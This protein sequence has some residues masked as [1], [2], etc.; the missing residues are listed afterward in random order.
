MHSCAEVPTEK[1]KQDQDCLKLLSDTYTFIKR[2][3]DKETV[4]ASLVFRLSKDSQ[5]V[6][7]KVMPLGSKTNKT[8][9][10]DVRIACILNNLEQTPV[11]VKTSGWIKCNQIPPLWIRNM[12]IKKDAP[13]AFESARMFLFQVMSFSSHSWTDGEIKLDLEEYRV[14]LFLLLHGLWVAE[15]KIHFRHNDI[16]KG[17]I[18]FQACK[19]N[20]SITISIGE[21]RYKVTCQRFVPKLIDFGHATTSKEEEE[22]EEEEYSSEGAGLFER[23]PEDLLHDDVKQLFYVFEERMQQEGLEPFKRSKFWTQIEDILLRD[24]IFENIR[25]FSSIESGYFCDVCSSI[26]NVQWEGKPFYFC[27]DVCARVYSDVFFF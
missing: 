26:A 5:E 21:N 1:G 4:S 11:F 22:E 23:S 17:Q 20:T 15:K 16:H 9:L 25:L 13:R 18:L 19:P 6:A 3:G 27:N 2:V 7:I 10:Q 24:P 14:M 12:N 8:T